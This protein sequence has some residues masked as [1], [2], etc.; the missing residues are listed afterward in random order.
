M[1]FMSNWE[2]YRDRKQ[3]QQNYS[4]RWP[5]GGPAISRR[6]RAS[7]M[8]RPPAL[9]SGT[10]RSC[11]TFPGNRIPANRIHP[12]SV[13]LLEFYPEPNATGT[14][15]TGTVNNYTGIQDR[16]ID[17]DQFTQRIDFVQS[18]SSTWMGRYSHSRDDEIQPCAEVERLE[19]GQPDSS[20]DGRQHADAL[21]DRR[22]RIPV[23]LQLVLQHVRARA[24]VRARRHRGAGHPW[25]EA[26]S[27]NR[28]GHSEH[29]HQRVE[30]LW[31]QHRGAV[32]QQQQGVRVHRQRVVDQG[33]PLVQGG[34][35]LPNR[36]LQPG[37]QPVP[38]RRVPVRRPGDRVVDRKRDA[39]RAPRSPTSCSATSVSPSCRSSWRSR[40]S[41]RSARATT[42][43]T[44]GE[45]ATT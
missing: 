1:F 22:Q 41:A 44:P 3:N 39:D 35:P 21:A 37:R 4:C 25:H 2:G 36:P 27:G 10:T 7:C 38:A 17:K 20:G 5:P 33:P 32:H 23:W 24:G 14:D 18:S 12:T 16:V 34:R 43:P 40:N 11:A 42:S 31:R 6:T 45:C 26:A 15:A 9:V 30:R 28:L 13:K 29:R 19:A 8:T